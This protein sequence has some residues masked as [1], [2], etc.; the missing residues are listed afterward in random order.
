MV[1][2]RPRE[3][4]HAVAGVHPGL[5]GHGPAAGRGLGEDLQATVEL[6]DDRTGSCR[7]AGGESRLKTRREEE[8]G[9]E[10]GNGDQATS[11]H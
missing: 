2:P 8:S 11:L 9:A 7:R 1:D 3:D 5:P 10:E 6:R 4:L